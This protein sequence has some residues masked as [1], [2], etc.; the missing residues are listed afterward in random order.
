MVPLSLPAVLASITQAWT[1]H[2]VATVND[3]DVRVVK[4]HGEFVPHAHEDTDEFFLVL[5]GQLTIRMADAEV[6]LQTGDAYVVPRGVRHQPV[7]VAGASL[8]LLEPSATANTGDSPG[9]LTAP[10]R[11]AREQR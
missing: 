2:T 9:A 4:A 11:L 5:D 3:Y 7:S 8:L 10:R 1:P 6:E